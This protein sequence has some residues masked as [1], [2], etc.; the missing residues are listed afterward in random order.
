M[1][2]GIAASSGIT[3]AKAY[4]LETPEIIIE[5]VESDPVVE[6]E[7]FNRALEQSKRDIEVI[8]LKAT[9]RLSEEELKIFDAHLMVCQDSALCDGVIDK[10]NSEMV[11][12]DF[13]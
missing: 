5:R 4:K 7:K 8:K 13:L 9:G 6:I 11:N 3:I 2:K 12:A 1:L 10:I